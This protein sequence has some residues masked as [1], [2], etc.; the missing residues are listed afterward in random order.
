MTRTTG[1]PA[2]AQALSGEVARRARRHLVA[3][4]DMQ[5]LSGSVLTDLS[6]N[7]NNATFTAAPTVTAEG[8]TF[9]GTYYA[10]FVLAAALQENYSFVVVMKGAPSGYI[11]FGSRNVTD[12]IGAWL[13]NN[14]PGPILSAGV[15]SN[16]CTI[17]PALTGSAYAALI[18]KVYP[19]NQ[20]RGK[21]LGSGILGYRNTLRPDFVL[22][23][24]TRWRIGG[25]A[26]TSG[27][28]HNAPYLL[29][30][31]GTIAYIMLFNTVTDEDQD[32]AILEYITA[33]LAPRGITL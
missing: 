14:S 1:N 24:R 20:A 21:V 4:F 32:G 13:R 6:G 18:G 27:G 30:D 3:E 28:D 12:G 5:T 22:D 9:N 19:G 29:L 17:S 15:E 7:G 31:T 23:T 10:D 2:L 26:Q 33:T 25:A 11:V 16:D 8:I